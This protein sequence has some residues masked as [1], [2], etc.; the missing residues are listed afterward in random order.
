M[1]RVIHSLTLIATIYAKSNFEA[2]WF[3]RE[4]FDNTLCF[5]CCLL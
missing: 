3:Y 1:Q 5:L 2:C 4:R